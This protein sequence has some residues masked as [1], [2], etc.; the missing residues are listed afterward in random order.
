MGD[1]MRRLK[2][3]PV[4]AIIVALALAVP[5]Y[6][7]L[8]A[9]AATADVLTYG[10]SGGTNI[11]V[12]SNVSTAIKSGTTAAIEGAGSAATCSGSSI[13]GTVTSNP[14][15]PS[16]AKLSIKTLAISGCKS[17]GG[18]NYTVS[19]AGLPYAESVTSSGANTI[20]GAITMTVTW[21]SNGTPY[22]CIYTTGSLSGTNG[23]FTS[24]VLRRSGV[25]PDCDSSVSVTVGFATP[26]DTSVGGSPAVYLG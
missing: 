4:L 10:S 7:A 13:T 1:Q 15:S 5:T 6:R 9:S 18:I 16:T 3:V 11:A 20:T 22:K 17:S 14:A 25:L 26:K 2:S 24:Q 8:S 12:N 21:T 19:T 23:K